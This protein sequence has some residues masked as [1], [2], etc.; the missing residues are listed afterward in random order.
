[1]G[2]S[3]EVGGLRP[4]VLIVPIG[5]PDGLCLWANGIP[6]VGGLISVGGWAFW[7]RVEVKV[8][9]VG[10]GGQAATSLTG[11]WKIENLGNFKGY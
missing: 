10:P 7:M 3:D 4:N 1:M 5:L 2:P 11:K 8:F 9:R 6:M